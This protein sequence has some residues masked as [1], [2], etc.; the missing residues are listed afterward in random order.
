MSVWKVERWWQPKREKFAT[1]KFLRWR[2]REKERKKRVRGRIFSCD[3]M[4][5]LPSL[6]CF[7]FDRSSRDRAEVPKKSPKL[8]QFGQ[9]FCLRSNANDLFLCLWQRNVH[10]RA[11]TQF[12]Y[13]QSKRNLATR[14]DNNKNGI[15]RVHIS[16][17]NAGWSNKEEVFFQTKHLVWTKWPCGSVRI[18]HLNGVVLYQFFGKK[19]VIFLL[20]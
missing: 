15:E 19:F 6:S 13:T 14:C 1:I 12:V 4:R 10:M 2:W 5:A 11:G 7:H 3:S 8:L 18:V 9:K 17:C 16:R 20:S